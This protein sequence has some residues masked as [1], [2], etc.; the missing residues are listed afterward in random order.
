MAPK[1]GPKAAQDVPKAAQGGPKAAQ[2]APRRP[3]GT[4][5]APKKPPK[6]RPKNGPKTD[7]QKRHPKFQ[8]LSGKLLIL[9]VKTL[10]TLGFS[11]G[12][13]WKPRG[14]KQLKHMRKHRFFRK[15]LK[16]TRV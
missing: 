9:G 7:P 14:P 4:Q 12:A 2:R 5:K 1:R 8:D 3:Q 16:N 15:N 13:P 11:T 10:K 6:R